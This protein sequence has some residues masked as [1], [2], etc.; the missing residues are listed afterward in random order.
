[1]ID[2]LPESVA[3]YKQT[4]DF[5]E[6]TVPTGLLDAH[7]TKASVWGR[8][9]VL[10]GELIYRIL[11]PESEEVILTC[12]HVGI[13]EPAIKHQVALMGPVTF[14]VEFYKRNSP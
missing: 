3:K 12:D 5:T 13:V 2:T 14:R 7:Q 10:K 1:M 4:P 6:S 8:I 11:E 9:V